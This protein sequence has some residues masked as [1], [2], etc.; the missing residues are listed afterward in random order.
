MGVTYPL[1]QT[2]EPRHAHVSDGSLAGAMRCK[3][4]GTSTEQFT[5][6][7]SDAE[8]PGMTGIEPAIQL[9]KALP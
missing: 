4:L 3:R 8:M 1:Q 5:C 6:L 7:L 2:N 9:P